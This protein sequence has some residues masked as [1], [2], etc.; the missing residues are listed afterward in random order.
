MRIGASPLVLGRDQDRVLKV[1]RYKGTYCDPV[2][3]ADAAG[4]V[5][6]G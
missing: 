6:W 1:G 5:G 4:E 2:F 3:V